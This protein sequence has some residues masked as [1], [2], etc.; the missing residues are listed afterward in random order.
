MGRLGEIFPLVE[1]CPARRS[2]VRTEGAVRHASEPG[3][4][5]GGA[6]K[7]TDRKDRPRLPTG[8]KSPAA[9]VIIHAAAGA[10]PR[11]E[12]RPRLVGNVAVAIMAGKCDG[13]A[14][15]DGA[16]AEERA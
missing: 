1:W 15:G 14:V 16:A 3:Y 9:A 2:G 11:A 5:A 4:R 12:T 7:G 6:R 13:E 8:M 10:S